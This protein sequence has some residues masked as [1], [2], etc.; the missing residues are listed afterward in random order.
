[1]TTFTTIGKPQPLIDG[2][3]KITG[4]LR[5]INDLTFP[6][7]LHAR[8]VLS[9]EAHA[10]INSI[11][12][13]DALA[14]RG[15]EYVITA[16]DLPNIP[17]TYRNKLL[18][19]SDRVL[20]VGHPV[21]IVL[22]NSPEAAADAIE[23]IYVD[24]ESLPAVVTIDDALAPDAP[25]IWPD[26]IPKDDGSMNKIEGNVASRSEE[27]RGD[28]AK[29]LAQADVIIE[30]RF[31][32]PMVH[33]SSIEPQGIVAQPNPLT[34]GMSVW[35][36]TQTP[37]GIR[38][39]IADILGIPH[40]DVQVHAVPVGG[41]FGGKFGLY[42]SLIS[43]VSHTVGRPVKMI[44][45]RNEELTS[46][47]PA[48]AIR[49]DAK[50]GMK[51]DGSLSGFQ[52]EVYVDTGIYPSWMA[53]HATYML[54]AYYPTSDF[55]VSGM[56]VLTNKQ[57]AGSYRAPTAPTVVFV[58]DTLLDEAAIRLGLD[59]LELK[60]KNCAKEG[61]LL[62]DGEAWPA[63]AMQETIER[64]KQHP[65]WQKR[66]QEKR[67]G[68]GIG[69]GVGGWFGGL[70]PA[71]AVCKLSRDGLVHIHTGTADLTGVTTVFAMLAA[72]AF[73]V[74][75]ENVR[76]MYSDT[77]TAPYAGG[78]GGSKTTYTLGN[79][80]VKAAEEAKRQ[81]L[82]IASEE[83][84]AAIE[85]LE[86]A[87]TKV[88]VKGSPD[89]AINLSDIAAKTMAFGGK[90]APVQA[91]GRDA[92]QHG[93]PAFSCQIAEVF[94]DEETGEVTVLN[95][96]A[97]QD[98]G[99]ALNPLIVQGQMQGGAVQGIGWALYE[100]MLYDSMGQLLSGT[101]MDYALPHAAQAG[102]IETIILEIPSEHGPKGVGEAPVIPTA[103]AIANAI[104]DATG[105]RLSELPMTAPRV[106]QAI[107]ERESS[108]TE[109]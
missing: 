3:A 1:M 97:I 103:A 18:L 54:G 24:Y 11:D 65:L 2:K 100:Q 95:L 45:T 8:F 48:P 42:E 4:H 27:K 6:A 30:H 10:R 108:T 51:K 26:G 38:E 60:S 37:F 22:A 107:Q 5:Y 68:Y 96:V 43:L 71:A 47:N 106:L 72:E 74:P 28:V 64:A 53:N 19:A 21:A 29:A 7:M 75:K 85:D 76:V 86:I 9:S 55:L 16:K 31:E 35:V 79:A 20:F 77:D 104:A 94:V 82:E 50:L 92:V 80:V 67:K 59:P 81:V 23:R 63:M 91:I 40:S 84:E 36:S 105:L 33:Q 58:I 66:S 25:Q 15:V 39:E 99:R 52:A 56:N 78:V 13:S 62:P 69:M 88:Q 83:F 17:A 12:I 90:Y 46:T 109:T 70:E 41:A 61:D 102:N 87:E 73:G 57:S 32:T 93:A 101:L 89:K 34:D 44:L 98:V 14:V 49:V